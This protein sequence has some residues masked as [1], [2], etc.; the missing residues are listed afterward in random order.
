[1]FYISCSFDFNIG[2]MPCT[3]DACTVCIPQLPYGQSYKHD[4]P[5]LLV[6]ISHAVP[7]LP[8]DTSKEEHLPQHIRCVSSRIYHIFLPFA[9]SLSKARRQF[10]SSFSISFFFASATAPIYPRL[11]S[12]QGSRTQN[13][14]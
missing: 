2:L 8:Y 4:K 10:C 11:D 14:E 1:M 5:S 6:A 9:S 7:S 12:N 3:P 13:P